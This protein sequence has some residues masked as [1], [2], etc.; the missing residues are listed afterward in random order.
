MFTQQLPVTVEN[1]FRDDRNFNPGGMS[2]FNIRS[3][4]KYLWT[5]LSPADMERVHNLAQAFAADTV[6]RHHILGAAGQVLLTKVLP[7]L[8]L[9]SRFYPVSDH[10]YDYLGHRLDT[11]TVSFTDGFPP[12]LWLR[13]E[14]IYQEFPLSYQIK[15]S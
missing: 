2:D 10:G 7:Y 5:E 8:K 6:Q 15:P 11:K 13:R 4:N 14:R 3:Y 1:D 12:T 9:N